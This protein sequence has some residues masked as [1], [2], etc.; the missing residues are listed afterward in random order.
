MIRLRCGNVPARGAARGGASLIT[1]PCFATSSASSHAPADTCST[2]RWPAPRSSVRRPPNAPRCAAAS[3]PRPRPLTTVNPARRDCP[4]DAR[5]APV[6]N[7]FRA[8]T[9]R[10][11]WPSRRWRRKCLAQTGRPADRANRARGADRLR[12]SRESHRLPSAGKVPVRLRHRSLLVHSK[13]RGHT[14]GADP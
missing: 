8:A 13:S 14:F 4:P 3:M 7:G 11:Q 1:A 10:L 9:Q 12:R 2:R 5:P 6:R